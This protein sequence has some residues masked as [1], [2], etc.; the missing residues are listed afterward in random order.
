MV[1]QPLYELLPYVY[2]LIG[3][4]GV[5]SLESGWGKL[6]GLILIATGIVVQQLRARHR[7]HN[8]L[9]SKLNRARSGQ[10][11]PGGATGEPTSRRP[12]P[13]PKSRR[14]MPEPRSKRT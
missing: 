8:Q 5:I 14:S 7:A 6:S 9:F 2:M 13:E 1:P 11:E 4:F 12:M 10:S 3:L